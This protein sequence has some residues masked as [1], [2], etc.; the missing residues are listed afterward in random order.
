MKSKTL[1]LVTLFITLTTAFGCKKQATSATATTTATA[2]SKATLSSWH[3]SNSAWAIR[4]DLAANTSGSNFTLIVKFS[5]NSEIHCSS[6]QM[7][8]T[9]TSGTYNAGTCVNAFGGTF[10]NPNMSTTTGAATF[11]TG[12]AGSYSNSG[13][14]LTLCSNGGSCSTYY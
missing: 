2:T 14:A 6:T 11:D 9:S 5:D 4:L 7:S 1:I 13:S 12:G 8:G 3:T 10:G